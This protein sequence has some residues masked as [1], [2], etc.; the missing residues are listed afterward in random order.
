M[1]RSFKN[2]FFAAIIAAIFSSSLLLIS[3]GALAQEDGQITLEEII[4]SARG[5]ATPVASIPGGVE[6]ATERE[7]NTSPR[8]GSIVDALDKLP[9]ISRTGESPYA[10]DVSIRGLSGPS[11]VILI[12]GKRINTATDMNAR[13]GYINAADVERIEV[14]KGPLSALYGSGSTGGVINII[15]RKPLQFTSDLEAHGRINLGGS[16]NPEGGLAYGYFEFT[17][18]KFWALVSTGYRHYGTTYGFDRHRVPNS[19]FQDTGGRA[20][21]SFRPTD[22]LT[23]TT[24]AIRTIAHDVGIPG[25]NTAMPNIADIRYP[26]GEFTLIS[27]D[28]ELQV[29]GDYLKKLEA[30]LYYTSNRRRVR[31]TNVG[32]AT[33][34]PIELLPKADH[35]TWGGKIVFTWQLNSHTLLTG[36][37]FW[38]WGINSER[39]RTVQMGNNFYTSLDHPTPDS[40]QVSIGIFASD[41]YEYSPDLS[42][43]FGGR[44][45][46][47]KTTNSDLYFKNPINFSERLLFP[48]HSSQDW[49]W[50]LHL[51]ASWDMSESLR[52]NF[53]LSSAYRA[54]DIMERFKYINLAGQYELYGNPDLAPE[55]SIF[56]EYQLDYYGDPF[57]L[58]F[59]IFANFIGNYIAERAE[60]PTV[61][62]LYNIASARIYGTELAAGITLPYGFDLNGS[63]TYLYGQDRANDQPLA[64]VAPFNALFSLEYHPLDAFWTRIEHRY[65]APQTRTPAGV[66]RSEKANITSLGF[67]FTIQGAAK[68]EISVSVDNIFDNQYHNYLANQRGYTIWEPGTSASINYTLNF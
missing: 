50:Q 38:T 18:P 27:Q 61:R 26:R 3:P 40:K 49:G 47:L 55:R 30:D 42:F 68:H 15:T 67:G 8:H 41:T 60:S 52:S 62:R 29:G 46:R 1:H 2:I 56:F 36:A 53:L 5:Y 13:L 31:I 20:S 24:E 51:G 44:L 59:S 23:L 35:D 32:P 28:L 21:F 43:Y 48:A 34:Q 19:Q 17:S 11:I 25:G 63:L 10:Q 66:A 39:L 57:Y 58:K 4:V 64:Q 37:D 16:T 14:L 45:D 22:S 54:A 65:I 9:G 6:V 12:N 33:P 7:I